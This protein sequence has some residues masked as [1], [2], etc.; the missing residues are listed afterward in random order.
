MF[1]LLYLV[2]TFA[3]NWVLSSTDAM[4]S[5]GAFAEMQANLPAGAKLTTIDEVLAAGRASGKKPELAIPGKDGRPADPLVNL[6]YTSG[7]SGRPKGAE[8][9]EHL[10]FDFLKVCLD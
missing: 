6:M 9:P 1:L 5:S 7:S 10:F 3:F 8:Y 4:T 2:L